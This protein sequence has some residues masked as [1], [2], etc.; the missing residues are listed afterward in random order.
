MSQNTSRIQPIF[1]F[2]VNKKHTH[3]TGERRSQRFTKYP[4]DGS[5]ALMGMCEFLTYQLNHPQSADGAV[6]SGL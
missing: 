6:R 3:F 5:T 4:V 2:L 1:T